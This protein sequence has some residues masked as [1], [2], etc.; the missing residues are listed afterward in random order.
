M[1]ES[2]SWMISKLCQYGNRFF[3]KLAVTCP[4][5]ISCVLDNHTHCIRQNTDSE[6]LQLLFLF[7]FLLLFLSLLLL[8]LSKIIKT[9]FVAS[10]LNRK[11]ESVESGS[12]KWVSLFFFCKA[13]KIPSKWTFFVPVSAAINMFSE[14]QGFLTDRMTVSSDTSFS[15]WTFLFIYFILYYYDVLLP[16]TWKM[17]IDNSCSTSS[18]YSKTR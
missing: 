13:Y 5:G 3:C 2:F 18:T 10:V 8:L 16:K 17:W 9:V 6:D 14:K 1:W 4:N 12:Y 15:R 11:T 7:I